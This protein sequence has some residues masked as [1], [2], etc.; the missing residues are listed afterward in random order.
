MRIIEDI[1]PAGWEEWAKRAQEKLDKNPQVFRAGA[2]RHVYGV[3][4]GNAF[5][6]TQS[7]SSD[8]DDLEWDGDEGV[9]LQEGG[10]TEEEAAKMDKR[11]R[12]QKVDMGDPVQWEPEPPLEASQ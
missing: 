10:G 9:A 7:E 11:L 4:G 3:A 8:A 6:E 1:K 5:V 12:K 2:S